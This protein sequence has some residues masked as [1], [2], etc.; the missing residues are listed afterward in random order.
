MMV[1]NQK[2]FAYYLEIV[3]VFLFVFKINKLN[4]IN[5]LFGHFYYT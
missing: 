5:I 4:K 3:V 1:F 2:A